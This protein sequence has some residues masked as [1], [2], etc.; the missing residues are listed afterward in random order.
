M[1]R[2]EL[3]FEKLAGFSPQS[4]AKAVSNRLK[5]IEG[6]ADTAEAAAKLDKTFNQVKSIKKMQQRAEVVDKAKGVMDKVKNYGKETWDM[7]KK[8]PGRT[9]GIAAVGAGAGIGARSMMGD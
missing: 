7:V 5:S 2:A 1:D 8:N 9:A 4:I 6:M 3:L